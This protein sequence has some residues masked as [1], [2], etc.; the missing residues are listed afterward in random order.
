M[1]FLSGVFIPVDALP[2]GLQNA[3]HALPLTYLSDALHQVMNDGNGLS[4]IWRDLAGCLAGSGGSVLHACDPA[5]SLGIG[6]RLGASR[7]DT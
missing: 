5:V 3:V 1:M 4:A 7:W 6:D 2:S